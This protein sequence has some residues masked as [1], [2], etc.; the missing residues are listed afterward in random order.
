MR[1]SILLLFLIGLPMLADVAGCAC[2]T[3]KPETMKVRQCSL[4]NESEKHP[5]GVEFFFLKDNNPRKPNRWLLLPRSHKHDGKGMLL[6][7]SRDERIRLWSAAIARAR[8]LWGDE[9]GVA[10][11]GDKVRTQC[12]GHIHIGKLLRYVELDRRFIVISRIEDIPV[13]TDGT[14]LW[15]HPANDKFHVHL[16]EQ[17]CETVLLR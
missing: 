17:T 6:D 2:D 5:A 13:P 15:I 11:N 3:S 7:M 12:H 4:C 8:E 1:K 14:G 10:F 9:W 16:G